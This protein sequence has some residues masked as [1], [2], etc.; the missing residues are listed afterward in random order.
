MRGRWRNH[1][2]DRC[3]YSKD[4]LAVIRIYNEVCAPHGFYPVETFSKAL[5]D[6]LDHFSEGGLGEEELNLFRSMFEEAV[7]LHSTGESIYNTPLGA[8]LI[9]ILW[10]NY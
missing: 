5:H 6:T 2:L 10:N 3:G 8:K 7:E 1:Q 4:G 9:R